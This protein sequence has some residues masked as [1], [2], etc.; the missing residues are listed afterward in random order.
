MTQMLDRAPAD[1]CQAVATDFQ[2]EP[3]E[4]AERLEH[5]AAR[6][7][8]LGVRVD[9]A[10]GL[11]RLTLPGGGSATLALT[12][13]ADLRG[14]HAGTHTLL[15]IVEDADGV[16]G[17]DRATIEAMIRVVEEVSFTAYESAA[18]D[19]Q[20]PL[21]L[22]MAEDYRAR[23]PL[24]GVALIL[25]GHFVTDLVPM[26]DAAIALGVPAES[27]TVLRKEYAYKM[28]RRIDAS[29]AARGVRTWPV[30]QVAEAVRD[31]AER[32]ATLGLRCLA[33]DDGGYILPALLTEAADV[34]A[35][36]VGVVEQ[37]MSGIFKLE[38]FAA[39]PVP[40]LAVAQSRLK[41][42]IESTWIADTA[43][44]NILDILPDEKPEG[45]PALILGY[46]NIGAAIAGILRN[47]GMRVAVY[48]R[49]LVRLISAH[50]TGYLTGTSL[51]D[52]LAEHRPLLVI[53]TTGRTSLTEEHY[54]VLR[55]DCFLASVSSRNTEFD[56]PALAARAE[57]VVDLGRIGY[58]YRLGD[59]V[60]VT[61]LADGYPV[62]FHQ[63]DSVTKSHSDLICAALLLGACV[64]ADNGHGFV[65]GHNVARTDAVLDA[66][67]LLTAYYELYG[68]KS[69]APAIGR[70]LNPELYR[71][72]PLGITTCDVLART[73]G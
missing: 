40:V 41:A 53:G 20:L 14:H 62:N 50:E 56:L 2:A 51:T 35:A 37:T 59:H 69:D 32:A 57:S 52:L 7:A 61:V 10:G 13:P 66:S 25:T 23:Q 45:Q 27:I 3:E 54:A 65:N 28:R 4:A 17:A 9:G 33:I 38:P 31:H 30:G 36:Y 34:Q 47:R 39:L 58:R 1:S 15:L 68:P 73:C 44:F 21:M 55:R 48:D 46:G 5:C 22:G 71:P 24:A 19:A 60:N 6:L 42:S 43:I 72:R 63:A 70:S 67:G 12:R 18:L 49:D 16:S 29:L 26:V 64:L 8:A 11:R